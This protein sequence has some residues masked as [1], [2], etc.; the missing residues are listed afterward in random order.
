MDPSVKNRLSYKAQM[1]P[2][3]TAEKLSEALAR[4]IT[5]LRMEKGLSK[6]QTANRAG[7]STSFVTDLENGKR[8]PTVETLVKLAWAFG[9]APSAMLAKCEQEVRFSPSKEG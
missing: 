6:V 5:A 9:L 1:Q 8:R 7:L 3:Q 4:Q 2:R